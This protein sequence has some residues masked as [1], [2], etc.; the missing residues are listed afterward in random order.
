MPSGLPPNAV[1]GNGQRLVFRLLGL[2]ARATVVMTSRMLTFWRAAV[3]FLDL[4]QDRGPGSSGGVAPPP[5]RHRAAL[6]L[7]RSSPA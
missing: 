3:C 5:R 6:A 7:A 2:N 4:D 1:K